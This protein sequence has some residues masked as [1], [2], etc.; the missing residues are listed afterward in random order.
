MVLLEKAASEQAIY[1]EVM[2][3]R[4]FT[5]TVEKFSDFI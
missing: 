4:S 5:L 1:F 2:T 3:K